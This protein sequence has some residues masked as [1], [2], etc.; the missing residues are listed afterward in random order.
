MATAVSPIARQ[1]V[2]RSFIV[3]VSLLG[4]IALAQIAAVSWVFV[5]RFAALT[6]RA[7]LG[8]G[9]IAATAATPVPGD[10]AAT[11]TLDA[12]DPFE[13]VRTSIATSEPIAPPQK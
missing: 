2:G 7:K 5:K 10:F 6:E 9:K 4:C 8:P 3:A 11:A 1:S 12:R 13:E